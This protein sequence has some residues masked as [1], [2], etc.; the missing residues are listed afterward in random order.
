MTVFGAGDHRGD[1]SMLG[2]A[3]PWAGDRARFFHAERMGET[4]RTQWT[5]PAIGAS[6]RADDRAQLH[7][8]F[9]EIAVGATRRSLDERSEPAP[10]TLV[11]LRVFFGSALIS[12]TRHSTR[13][14]LPSSTGTA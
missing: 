14:T 3:Q 2:D 11:R 12:S 5:M 1:R 10:I 8:G 13:R 4:V 7:Q 6:W 9:V